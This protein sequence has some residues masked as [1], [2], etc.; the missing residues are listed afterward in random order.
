MVQG[1]DAALL[2]GRTMAATL[3]G[4]D[5]SGTMLEL[6]QLQVSS[7]HTVHERP[8]PDLRL[9]VIMRLET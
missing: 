7:V 1:V 2:D 9:I 4:Y 3:L 6:I 8:A 5:H